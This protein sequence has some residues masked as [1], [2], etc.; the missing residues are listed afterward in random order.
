MRK[1]LLPLYT[2]AFSLVTASCV[3]PPFVMPYSDTN[4]LR[5]GG[6]TLV[7]TGTKKSVP[8]ALILSI[9]VRTTKAEKRLTKAFVFHEGE[10]FAMYCQKSLTLL[11]PDPMPLRERT[12]VGFIVI[13]PGFAPKH[14]PS[15]RIGK[16]EHLDWPLRPAGPEESRRTLEK[17]RDSLVQGV[18]DGETLKALDDDQEGIHHEWNE[19]YHWPSPS[20]PI[21]VVLST[22]D[23][24]RANDYIDAALLRL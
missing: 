13:A 4:R 17:L 3:I 5:P 6:L 9:M 11:S 21:R 16:A 18:I 10:S 14:F 19:W 22:D 23:L 24:R 2:L 15:Q 20:K 1:A 12:L 8:E 7:E